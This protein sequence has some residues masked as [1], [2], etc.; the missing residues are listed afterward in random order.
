MLGTTYQWF[1]LRQA[2]YS[3]K[4]SCTAISR[5]G[6]NLPDR[7]CK[8]CLG[9]GFKFTDYLVR[10]YHWIGAPGVE[11]PGGPGLVITQTKQMVIQHDRTVNRFDFLLILDQEKDG[12]TLK[13]P[14]KIM[15]QFCI[16]DVI[17]LRADNARIEFW[18]CFLEERTVNDYRPGEEGTNFTYKGN[19]SNNAPI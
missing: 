8:R 18:K 17:P 1:G 13:T 10:G 5:Q 15:R 12:P 3:K 16:Q 7:S 2:D 6:T 14:F 9:M 11:F 4:C 19:R